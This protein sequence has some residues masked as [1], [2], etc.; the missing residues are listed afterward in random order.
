MTHFIDVVNS[1]LHFVNNTENITSNGIVHLAYPFEF[2]PPKSGETDGGATI[3]ISNI[4]RRIAG[5][6]RQI[7]SPIVVTIQAILASNP[8]MIE[9]EWDSFHLGHVSW[10]QLNMTGHLTGLNDDDELV[11]KHTFNPRIAPGLF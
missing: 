3:K 6:V 2:Q 1:S 5:A 10:D 4:D 9:Q 8:D 11:N 7:S